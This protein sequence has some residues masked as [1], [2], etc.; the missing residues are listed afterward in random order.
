[1]A[2]QWI[3]V[4]D[5]YYLEQLDGR[6]EMHIANPPSEET[7][8]ALYDKSYFEGTAISGYHHNVFENRE[9]QTQKAIR[10]VQRIRRFLPRGSTTL[11][12]GCGPGYFVAEARKAGFAVEGCDIAPVATAYAQREFGIDISLGD[13][14]QMPFEEKAY[15][16]ITMFSYLEH[17]LSPKDNLEKAHSLLES[18]GLLVLAIP[19]A[20]GIARYLQGR[21]WRGFSF[22]EHLHFYGKREMIALLQETDFSQVKTPLHDNNFF[23]DTVYY[24]AWKKKV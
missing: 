11:D 8:R 4:K 7:L 20:W 2:S 9:K 12:I 18:N 3:L 13:F 15:E 17:T 22:P 21:N 19:N 6:R 23:R 14:L 16:C 5:G 1:M 10:K 24:Y